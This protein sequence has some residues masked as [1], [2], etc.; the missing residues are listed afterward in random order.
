MIKYLSDN[1]TDFFYSNKIIE[2]E[3]REIYVYGLQ[4]IISTII[5]IT[6][7]LVLGLIINRLYYR[8][9]QHGRQLDDS[10]LWAWY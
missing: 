9:A 3:D 2:E 6:L 5:G 10:S 7:I 1:I 8:C 4:L